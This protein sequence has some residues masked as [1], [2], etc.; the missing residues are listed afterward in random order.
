AM[1]LLGGAVLVTAGALEL[2]RLMRQAR[3][4]HPGRM[5]AGW[6]STQDASSDKLGGLFA[7]T[8]RGWAGIA[9]AVAALLALSDNLE[10][11]LIRAPLPGLSVFDCSEY[12]GTVPILLA[13]SLTVAFIRALY[14]WRRTVLLSRLRILRDPLPRPA[15]AAN[16]LDMPTD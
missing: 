4:R 16:P 8:A 10:H 6:V 12:Q 13:I 14:R 1:V 3:R 7:M 2:L 15:A 5:A 9:A 11:A